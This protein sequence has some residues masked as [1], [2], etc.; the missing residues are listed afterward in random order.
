MSVYTIDPSESKFKENILGVRRCDRILLQAMAPFSDI[1][2]IVDAFDRGQ[3]SL[4]Q[5]KESCV[6]LD[7]EYD[8]QMVTEFQAKLA[9]GDEES[10]RDLAIEYGLGR[11]LA[12]QDTVNKIRKLEK[13][14][15]LIDADALITTIR[16][17]SRSS[18][19]KGGLNADEIAEKFPFLKE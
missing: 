18:L 19:K 15:P 14:N 3:V 10:A 12:L 16:E 11:L 6:R 5:A 8:H 7:E 9:T 2:F 17:R 13:N 4:E 1:S